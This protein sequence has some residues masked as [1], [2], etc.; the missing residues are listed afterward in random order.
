M[1][2]A[3]QMVAALASGLLLCFAFPTVLFGWHAPELGGLAWIALVPLLLVLRTQPPRRAFL[4]TF[5]AGL[6]L[7]GGS[8]YWIYGA[9]HLY[10]KL[11]PATSALLLFLL[12][13][14]LACYTALAPMIARFLELR[15]RGPF[16]VWLPLCWTAVELARN[17]FPFGG[18]PWPNLALSQWRALP[19]LQI[20]DVVGVYGLIFLIVWVNAFFAEACARVRGEA[21]VGLRS[22]SALTVVLVAAALGYGFWR[23]G[24]VEQAF[25][26]APELK[27]GIVQGNIPQ[28]EKWAEEKALANLHKLRQASRELRDAAVDLIVWPEASFPWPISANAGSIDP[29]AFGFDAQEFG[30]YPYLLFGTLAERSDGEFYNSAFLIDAHGTIV[31]RYHKAHLVPF[32]EYLPLKKFLFFARKL[33]APAGNFIAGTSS[34]PLTAGDA[35]LGPL[36]CYEDIFPEIARRFVRSGADALVNLSNDAWYGISS[37]PYQHIAFSVLRAVE[38]R[39]FLI[40]ATNTGVSAIITPIGKVQMATGIFENAVIVGTVGLSRDLTAATRLGDWFAWASLASVAVGLF[41]AL[42]T[43]RLRCGAKP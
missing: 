9:M 4:L 17:Y 6:A 7:Y 37:A 20:T 18:L 14:A 1:G 24:A 23:M 43:R 39:R 19:I 26:S 31:D 38:N 27:V 11:P 42:L 8:L 3:W 16:L 22:A 35:K 15:W 41:R 32:G 25:A 40:R 13:L 33:T 21:V 12:V 10:G 2:F 5:V 29:Q 34:A 36:I 30:T 28:E